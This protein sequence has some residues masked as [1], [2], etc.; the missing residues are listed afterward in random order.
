MLSISILG[1]K[2]QMDRLGEIDKQDIDS[3]HLDIM[4]GLFVDNSFFV[5]EDVV[6]KFMKPLDVHLMVREPANYIAYYSKYKPKYI[7]V[8]VEVPNCILYLDSIRNK[9]I[10]AGLAINPKTDVEVLEPYLP[11]V[12]MI[13]VMSVEPGLGGQNF[14]SS[15]LNKIK[16]IREMCDKVNPNIIIGVDGGVNSKNIK[17]CKE[18]GANHFVVGSYVTSSNMYEEVI[19]ELKD[20]IK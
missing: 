17:S 4:D 14:N 3:I 11:Y 10:G 8:H 15:S 2:D 12:D 16:K 7:T 18:A 5:G 1:M 19:G 6:S 20:K 13:L 9:Q